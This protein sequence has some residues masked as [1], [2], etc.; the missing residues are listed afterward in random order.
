MPTKSLYPPIDIPNVDIWT[1]LFERKDRE[2]PDDKVIFQDA[3]TKRSYTYA[4]IRDTA[5]EFGKGLKSTWNWKKGD[6]LALFTPNCVDTPAITWGTLWAGGVISPANP[7]YTV[8]ELA[9][10][11]K[12]SGAKAL[13]TQVPM[14]PVAREAA[15][16]AGIP[17]DRVILMG[18][19]R[20]PEARAKHFTSIRNISGASRYRKTKIDPKKDL[21]FL[22]Y[23]S[24]TTGLP[25]GVMLSHC[26]I[27]SNVCQNHRADGRYFSWNGGAD[28]KGDRIL[29]FLPFFHIYGLTCLIHNTMYGGYHAIIMSK[30]DIEKF[31]ANVQN[32]RIT[33]AYVVPPVVL[34]LSK[35]PVVD[36]YD[37]SSLRMMNSG[38]A[39]LTREL[40]EAA[41][42]RI[43]VGIKQGY[44][45]SE[46]S[47]TSHAQSWDEWDKYIGSVGKLMPNMEAKYMTTP[48]DGSE[49][50][51]VAVGEVGELYLRG[52]NVFLGYHNNPR[53]TA[54]C[55]SPDGWFRTGDVG[56]QDKEGNFYITDRVKELIKYKG[57]QV[58]P[59]ELEGILLDHEAVDDVAVI[60]VESKEHGSEVPRA[61][62]VR[63]A[64]SK[65][66]GVSDEEE[67]ANIVNWL[68]SKVAQHKRLRGGVR[69]IDAIPKSVSGKILRRVLK[70]K[71]KEDEAAAVAPKAKL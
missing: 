57:F 50:R 23:S 63:S 54:E 24:G 37:L 29:A 47:P 27:V 36:K 41:S 8:D 12:N 65:A 34:L 17:E 18:D 70:Q 55:L 40:V 43:K 39:P 71:A 44:G 14:L 21:A 59:A 45:L 28:G 13:V 49:P 68:N 46:T 60:G 5:L 52:P 30:F 26:N 1:F 42:S 35:H 7:T 6:V 20:D 56:Y 33:Y 9:F 69:F 38:A 51:E 62:V 25:K 53:A 11:L 15:Q 4:Q 67:A 22:V 61:Y 66:S 58:P 3:D 31:C 2:F 10:Q 32:Y 48:E 19:A 16:K 64:K